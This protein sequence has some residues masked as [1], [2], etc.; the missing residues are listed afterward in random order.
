[1]KKFFALFI[2]LLFGATAVVAAD[3]ERDIRVTPPKKAIRPCPNFDLISAALEFNLGCVKEALTRM[4]INEVDRQGNTA[5]HIA[6][7]RKR[8]DLAL[9]LVQQGADLHQKNFEGHDPQL[10]AEMI[11][12][13]ELAKKLDAIEWETRRFWI[14]IERRDLTAMK[15]SLKRGAS[16]GT[17]NVRLDNALHI[18]AQNDFPEGVIELFKAG[19]EI[20]QRN[21]LGETPLMSAALRN[22][23]EVMRIL[24]VAGAD[25]NALDERRKSPLDM[26]DARGDTKTMQLLRS[27][28]AKN[29]FAAEVE[30][31][32]S[33]GDGMMESAQPK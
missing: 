26:A 7:K 19:A 33:G 15:D 13:V 12:Q 5:L 23:F 27:F 10:L 17:R 22:H 1:M 24:L 28:G 2:L 14:A 20:N 21:H 3:V 11:W 32:F 8:A 25:A 4:D 31:S 9:F 30:F 16:I 29:G 6:V 18:A